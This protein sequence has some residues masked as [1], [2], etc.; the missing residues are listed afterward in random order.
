R[1]YNIILNAYAKSISPVSAHGNEHGDERDYTTGRDNDHTGPQWANGLMRGDGWLTHAGRH[2]SSPS[3]PPRLS[4]SETI[5]RMRQLIASMSR[6]ELP[7]IPSK[8][9]RSTSRQG[10]ATPVTKSLRSTSDDVT[11]CGTATSYILTPKTV[12]PDTVTPDIVTFNTLLDACARAADAD[13]A[14]DTWQQM[15]GAGITPSE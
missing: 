2:G 8:A 11:P 15:I 4:P 3:M 6:Q 7:P 13:A 9:V 10:N 1:S 12:A 14:V 5:Y